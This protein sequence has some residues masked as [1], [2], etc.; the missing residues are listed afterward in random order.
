M[1][2]GSP[3]GSRT[4]TRVLLALESHGQSYLRELSRLLASPLSVVQKAVRSLEKDQLITG[5]MI[6][7]TRLLD[8][9]SGYFA[10]A[11]LRGFLAALVQSAD[12]HEAGDKGKRPRSR[13]S[14]RSSEGRVARG[15][16]PGRPRAEGRS[17]GGGDKWRVW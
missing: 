16:R 11:R 7:R 3:F 1:E 15:T 17:E 10:L 9:N 14:G 4:R 6:G 13:G 12:G 8:L 2:V 5:R